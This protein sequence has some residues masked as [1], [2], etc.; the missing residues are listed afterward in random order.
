[1]NRV[2]EGETRE[3]VTETRFLKITM[4]NF[5]Y[6]IKDIKSQIQAALLIPSRI[7]NKENFN[8]AYQSQVAEN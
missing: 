3:D 4:K 7:N 1:M 8:Q 2:L 5:P 6:L